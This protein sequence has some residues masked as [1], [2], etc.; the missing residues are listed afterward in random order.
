MFFELA[1]T[2]S[3]LQVVWNEKQKRGYIQYRCHFG[4]N[5]QNNFAIFF[6]KMAAIEKWKIDFGPLFFVV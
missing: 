5:L 6:D 2:I 3:R 4:M 1:G